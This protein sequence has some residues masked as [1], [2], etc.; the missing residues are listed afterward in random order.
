MD[1]SSL[2]KDFPSNSIIKE[3]KKEKKVKKVVKSKP[4]VKKKTF[5]RKAAEMFTGEEVE[6]VFSYV[7]QD[8]LIPAAKDTLFSMITGGASMFMY[9]DDSQKNRVGRNGRPS[10]VSYSSYSEK[11]QYRTV[12]RKRS[13]YEDIY[14]G[15]RAEANEVLELMVEMIEEYGVVS[16]SDLYEMVGIESSYVD[17]N[18]GWENLS[19]AEIRLTREGFLLDLPR[20]IVIR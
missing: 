20:P 6:N 12:S 1:R 16:V 19:R 18:W 2:D 10:Y 14:L 15:T 4:K 9:G 13:N 3:E 5:G 8:I 7:L 11:P 17:N